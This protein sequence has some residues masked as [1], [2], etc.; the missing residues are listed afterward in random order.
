M[1]WT[2]TPR[3][4][5]WKTN[6]AVFPKRIDDKTWIWLEYYEYKVTDTSTGDIVTYYR[7]PL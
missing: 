1:K 2:V 6:F 7:L 5:T 4:D 3:Y